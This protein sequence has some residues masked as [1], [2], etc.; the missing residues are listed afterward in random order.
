MIRAVDLPRVRDEMSQ[1]LSDFGTRIFGVRNESDLEEY[2]PEQSS[3]DY[4]AKM[5]I[6]RLAHAELYHVTEGMADLVESASRNVPDF[7][8]QQEDL[9]SPFGLVYYARPIIVGEKSSTPTPIVA[10]SWGHWPGRNVGAGKSWPKGGVWVTIYSD[11]D[12]MVQFGFS[13]VQRRKSLQ[14]S[15]LVP[16]NH[17][18]QVPFGEGGTIGSRFGDDGSLSTPDAVLRTTW[19]LMSQTISSVED[20]HFDRAARRRYA[21]EQ[22]EPPPVRVIGLRNRSH[23]SGDSESD[24][25]YHHQWIVRGHWRK[26][27]YPSVNDHRPVWIAPHIKGPEGAPLLGGERVYSLK[28]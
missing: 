28:R 11:A 8:L 27:W 21:R 15:P 12:A 18:I 13:E 6:M 20:A 24:R 22:K 5:E 26:Q 4:L 16:M 2:V 17:E 19:L 1:F 9:P 23:A 25:E 3:G 10:M 7:S 14:M